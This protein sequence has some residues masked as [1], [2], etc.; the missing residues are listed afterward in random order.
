MFKKGLPLGAI[1]MLLILTLASIGVGYGLW[2]KTLTIVGTVNTGEVNAALSLEEI[3]ESD[4]YNALCPASGGGGYSI[5]KDCDGDGSLNDF[6]EAEGKDVA[7]CEAWLVSNGTYPDLENDGPQGMKVRITNGY[8]SFNCFVRYNV[9]NT[10]TIPI[11]IHSPKYTN[12][13][14]TAIHFNGWPPPC[15]SNDT[16]LEVD[17]VGVGEVA[18][19]N[20]HI[21]VEQ[22][23]EM[24]ATY[25]VSIEIL[26]HQWNEDAPGE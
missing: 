3:D 21:H 9:E 10:G 16:Q 15:Y 22:P 20:L 14:P 23:A 25:E 1:V 2:S 19:C 4:N 26:G 17:E 13:N 24:N 6:M 18:Y 12:L 5:G 7:L 11:K 8:P